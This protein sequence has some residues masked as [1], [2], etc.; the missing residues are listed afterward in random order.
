MFAIRSRCSGKGDV[1]RQFGMLRAELPVILV[2]LPKVIGRLFESHDLLVP[3]SFHGIQPRRAARR[4]QA[5]E[6]AD[7]HRKTNGPRG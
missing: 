2:T 7:D 5:C 3:Q 1:H 4:V 6:Q